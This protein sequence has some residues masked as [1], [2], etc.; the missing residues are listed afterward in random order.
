MIKDMQEEIRL[1]QLNQMQK[2]QLEARQLEISETQLEETQ[3]ILASHWSSYAENARALQLQEN[4]GISDTFSLS[5]CV[6]KF[7]CSS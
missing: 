7:Q 3:A 1:E 5:L 4:V 2:M 6:S